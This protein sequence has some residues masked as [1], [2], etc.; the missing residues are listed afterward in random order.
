MTININSFLRNLI[1]FIF[2]PVLFML[3]CFICFDPFY[4]FRTPSI[5]D[6]PKVSQNRGHFNV[7]LLEN[8][9][10]K[11]SYNA[12]L[13]ASS[14]GIFFRIKD[15]KELVGDPEL[16]GFHFEENRESIYGMYK[17]IL[18]LDENGHHL[19]Y[20]LLALDR[21]VFRVTFIKTGR[22]D[23]VSPLFTKSYKQWFWFIF[24][25]LV[26]FINPKFFIPYIVH[27]LTGMKL[28][29][30]KGVL[31]PDGF[32]LN[33]EANETSFE[34][35]ESKIKSGNFY[36]EKTKRLIVS[37]RSK[38]ID[39]NFISI[40]KKQKFFLKEINKIFN[41][42]GTKFKILINPLTDQIPLDRTSLDFLK[43]T[44]GANNVFDFSGKNA[45][46]ND[47]KN[48]YEETHYRPHV[49]KKMLETIYSN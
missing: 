42:H 38:S 1:C 28:P 29:F 22:L 46:T 19:K 24:E 5:E 13:L 18:Y 9:S 14:R 12:F 45:I 49:A 31:L 21:Q 3:V 47:Y 48:Y 2:I 27:E 43:L 25:N 30:M 6:L 16:M 32:T 10:K 8:N 7:K 23:R 40:K 4:F 20:M 39:K 26:T 36:T 17:K 15:W 37:K 41:K 35:L 34:S 33:L 44:F 11:T